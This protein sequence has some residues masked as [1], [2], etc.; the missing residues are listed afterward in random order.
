MSE[1]QYVI[2]GRLGKT[3]GVDG[4]MWV[5]VATDYPERFLDMKSI[6]VKGRDGWERWEIASS[7]LIGDRPVLTFA[8][9][10]SREEA[11]RHVNRDLAVERS[12]VVELP[13]DTYYVFDLIESDVIDEQTGKS[14]GRL[15]DVEPYPANDVYV[16]TDAHGKIIRLPAVKEFV[17][18]VDVAHKKIVVDIRALDEESA[19]G[20]AGS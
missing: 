6:L 18:R 20:S 15:T 13:D 3:R 16:V 1:E 10:H 14:L 8:H 4:A 7:E 12:Q 17:R 19:I 9:I 11:R 5:S 2:V